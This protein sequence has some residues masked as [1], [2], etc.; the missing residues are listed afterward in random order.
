MRIVGIVLVVVAGPMPLLALAAAAENP[1]MVPPVDLRNHPTM[2]W[3]KRTPGAGAPANPRMGYEASMGWDAANG[4]IIRWGGHNQGG[5][6]EQNFET[7]HYDPIRNTWVLSETNTSPPGNCCCRDNVFDPVHGR[8]IRFPAFFYSHGWQWRRTGYTRD[9]SAWSYDAA[10]KTWRNMRP[11]PEPWPRPLRGAV[12]DSNSQVILVAAGE[13]A[14]HATF[15]YDPHVNRWTWMRPKANLPGR[16][17]F[18]LAYDSKRNCFYAFGDQYGRDQ[19][20]WKYDLRSNSWTSLNPAHHPPKAGDGTVMAY[21]A[22]NDVVIANLRQGTDKGQTL[23]RETWAYLPGANDWKKLTTKGQPDPSGGRNTIMLYLPEYNVLVME[24]RTKKEQQ[25]W[26]FRYGPGQAR[27]GPDAPAGLCVDTAPQS[28]GLSWRPVKGAVRYHVYRGTGAKP[29]LVDYVRVGSTPARKPGLSNWELKRGTVYY[30]YVVAEDAE[31]RQGRLSVKVRTQPWVVQDVV[32]SALGAK[33]I[34]LTWKPPGGSDVVGY[35]VE[36]ADVRVYAM[37]ELK[38][39]TH[40]EGKAV[41]VPLA[42]SAVGAI[43][44]IG[45]FKQVSGQLLKKPH[46]VD[47]SVNLAAGQPA[48]KPANPLLSR[49][50]EKY[51]NPKGKPYAWSTYAYRIRAVNRLGVAGGDSPWFLTIPGPVTGVF[52]R[53]RGDQVDLKWQPHQG[54]NIVG[55]NI[56]RKQHRWNSSTIDRL[57]ARPVA[58]TAFTDA[59]AGQSTHRYFVAAVDALGQEG[60]IS[61]PVWS[62][63]EWRKYYVPFIGQWHQ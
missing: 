27:L 43:R 14:G 10:A 17:T 9:S 23:R 54:K 42:R 25:I 45:Q 36:R 56:Y 16:N 41:Y 61:S 37:S 31:K 13:G 26:T 52:A 20:T 8:F 39:L 6:G 55:Y 60:L 40:D 7:W 3:I 44:A 1:N 35:Q 29:W 11:L 57:N 49:D 47:K 28:A 19:R 22:T 18:G 12:W 48:A 62:Y 63:R 46:F 21:D 4:L 5:G 58:A 59:K 53:E 34:E 15:I 38:R 2:T 32:V 33:E 50:L 24:N 30:Y 51:R